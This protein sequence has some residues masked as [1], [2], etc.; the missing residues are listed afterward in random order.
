MRIC[1]NC[2]EIQDGDPLSCPACGERRPAIGWDR[3]EHVGRVLLERYEVVQRLGAG[4]TGAVYVGVDRRPTS[5]NKHVAIKFLHR[6][7]ST[8]PSLVARFRREALASCQVENPHVVRTLAFDELDDGATALIMEYVEGRSLAEVLRRHERLTPRAAVDVA[9][10]VAEALQAAHDAGIVHRDLKPGNIYLVRR[11]DGR[12]CVKV[13]DFGFALIKDQERGGVRLTKTGIIV[14]TP[15]YMAPEQTQRKA[16]VDNRADLYALGVLLYRMIA[17]VPPFD[18]RTIMELV[19]KHRSEEPGRLHERCEEGE[20]SVGLSD[21]VRKL[22]AKN[23]DDRYSTALEVRQ[24]LWSLD[25]L[26]AAPERAETAK[27]SEFE[28]SGDEGF[29]ETPPRSRTSLV[30]AAVVTVVVAL[31]VLLLIL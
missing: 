29:E 1:P 12:D 30:V 26:G 19:L 16:E 6:R 20:V 8:D 7:L 31:L 27:V 5:E 24:A 3:E 18:A 15:L 11:P 13:L 22:L 14:G 9:L 2:F 10:Q 21:V 23:P 17:G 25:S 4:T 28:S